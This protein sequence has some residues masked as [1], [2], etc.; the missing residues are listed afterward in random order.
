MVPVLGR[1][2]EER[3]QG[4]PGLSSNRQ[5]YLA[6]YLS[7]NTSIAA[8]AA[9]RVGAPRGE[10]EASICCKAPTTPIACR[11]SRR[12]IKHGQ[13][14]HSASCLQGWHQGFRNLRQFGISQSDVRNALATEGPVRKSMG[15]ASEHTLKTAPAKIRTGG[16][17]CRRT[18]SAGLG[19]C[20]AQLGARVRLDVFGNGSRL[21]GG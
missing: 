9:A 1:E 16:P 17:L 13:G 21:P 2:V 20:P 14:E 10:R 15:S 4:F 19:H 11:R 6:T 8:S 18:I 12:F 3:E 7:A 5:P